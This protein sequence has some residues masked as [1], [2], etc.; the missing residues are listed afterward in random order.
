MADRCRGTLQI[1]PWRREAAH[2]FQLAHKVT[3]SVVRPPRPSGSPEALSLRASGIFVSLPRDNAREDVHNTRSYRISATANRSEAPRSEPDSLAYRVR[4]VE[5]AE[6]KEPA[7]FEHKKP[8]VLRPAFGDSTRTKTSVLRPYHDHQEEMDRAIE[9]QLHAG[10]NPPGTAGVPGTPH[11]GFRGHHT[12]SRLG[13][14]GTPG[15]QGFRGHH[16]EFRAW[17]SGGSGD[18]TP[19]YGFSSGVPGTPHRISRFVVRT[20][21]RARRPRACRELGLATIWQQHW[22]CQPNVAPT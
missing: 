10:P 17:G 22:P 7:P 16:T 9:E 18:T 8:P 3:I 21:R 1:D 6:T 5:P 13:V 14:S 20:V 19:N 4:F 11:R 15:V 2:S 12:E